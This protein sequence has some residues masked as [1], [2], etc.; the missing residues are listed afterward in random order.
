MRVRRAAGLALLIAGVFSSS[1]VLPSEVRFRE[2]PAFRDDHTKLFESIRLEPVLDWASGEP[3]E[4]KEAVAYE[5]ILKGDNLHYNA[6]TDVYPVWEE[7]DPALYPAPGGG[8]VS[9]K[10]RHRVRIP[11][12]LEES[13]SVRY[14]IERRV[15]AT[16]PSRIAYVNPDGSGMAVIGWLGRSRG[17]LFGNGVLFRDAFAGISADVRYLN[18]RSGFEQDIIIK[19]ELPDPG[20]FG[21]DPARAALVVL[22][23]L[24]DF[25]DYLA[26]SVQVFAG[27]VPVDLSAR[28]A[29]SSLPMAFYRAG[30]GKRFL[31]SFIRGVAYPGTA[32]GDDGRCLQVEVRKTVWEENGKYYLW[33]EIPWTFVRDNPFPIT[34]DYVNRSGV[35]AASETWTAGPTYLVDGTLTLAANVTLTI[36]AG[37]VVKFSDDSGGASGI[38]V[39]GSNS[40]I[41]ALGTAN[42]PIVFTSRNDDTTGEIVPGSS[43]APQSGDYLNAVTLAWNSSTASRIEYGRFA[44]ARQAIEIGTALAGPV[45]HNR[46]E[47]STTGILCRP[48]SAIDLRLRNNLLH[49]LG[50]DGIV[51]EPASSAITVENCTL[52]HCA[53]AGVV[54]EGPAPSTFLRNNLFSLCGIGFSAETLP[55]GNND[56]N[57]YFNNQTNIQG[58]GAES[59]GVLLASSPFAGSEEDPFYLDQGCAL[60]NAGSFSSQSAGLDGFFTTRYAYPRF[61]DQ[62]QVDIGWHYPTFDADNDGMPDAWEEDNDLD[63]YADDAVSD[64]DGD[65]Y[66]NLAEYRGRSDPRNLASIPIRFALS[67][68]DFNGDGT[69]DIGVYRPS[70]SKWYISGVTNVQYGINTDIPVPGDYDGDGTAEIAVFRSSLG[71][72]YVRNQTSVLYGT[73]GDIPLPVDY[74]GDGSAD[75]AVFRPN[76]GRWWIKDQT[77]ISYG[78]IGD[79]PVPGYYNGSAAAVLS[80]FRPSN[81]VWYIRNLTSFAWGA[82]SDF[83]VPG[84]Y[85]GDG[86][87]DPTLFS[88]QTCS[89]IAAPWKTRYLGGGTQTYYFGL[90][91]DIPSPGDYSGGG[92]LTLGVFR[93]SQYYNWLR[94]GMGAVHYGLTGDVPLPGYWLGS[95]SDHDRLPDSWEEF[96]FGDLARQP[97]DDHPDYDQLVN[98]DEYQYG[99][100]PLQADT[101]GDGLSDYAEIHTHL[102]NPTDPDS[103]D[104]SYNDGLEVEYGADPLDPGDVPWFGG[105]LKNAGFEDWNAPG[106]EAYYWSWDQTEDQWFRSGYSYQNQ[107]GGGLYRE[108]STVGSL[109]QLGFSMAGETPYW[110]ALRAK[111]SGQIRL[112]IKYPASTYVSYA[113]WAYLSDAPWTLLQHQAVPPASGTEGGLKIQVCE[114]FGGGL[115]IDNAYLDSSPPFPAPTPVP[116]VPGSVVINEIGWMGSAAAAADEYVELYNTTAQP[117]V[118][119]GW[120]FGAYDGAPSVSL[121]G[122]I[123]A[124][125]YFLL[126]RTDDTT[127]SDLSAD[128]IYSGGLENN[129]ELLELK[130]AAGQTID[131]AGQAEGGWFA[132]D[133]SGELPSMERLDPAVAGTYEWNW[134]SND[135][136]LV[137][138]L[139]ADGNPLNSTPKNLNSAYY[140]GAPSDLDLTAGDGQVGLNWVVSEKGKFDLAGYNIFRK[141]GAWAYQ[142]V[143]AEPVPDATFVD[144]TVNNGT[145]YSYYIKSVDAEGNQSVCSSN[146]ESVT[147]GPPPPLGDDVI[148][149]EV[150][151]DPIGNESLYEWIELFNPTAAGILLDSWWIT[152]GEGRYTFPEGANLSL[153][154][155]EYLIMGA[156]SQ[157]AGGSAEVVYNGQTTSDGDISLSNSG[158][159][160]ILFNAQSEIVDQVS[161]QGN[162]IRE[163]GSSIA[164]KAVLRSSDF[165]ELHNVGDHAVDLSGLRI[166]DGAENDEL[167]AYRTDETVLD[168]SGFALI[169]NNQFFENYEIAVGTILV[170]C[171]DLAIGNGLTPQDDFILFDHDGSTVVSTYSSFSAVESPPENTSV[172]RI[173]PQTGDFEGNWGLCTDPSG[174]TPGRKNSLTP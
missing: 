121:S 174:S 171:G 75:L 8:W 49:D 82:G 116:A 108:A 155:G 35:L 102:T 163:E 17:E 4:E 164:R 60:V 42:G 107:F 125:G 129:G 73:E 5:V 10:N 81:A 26:D 170:T 128:Q 36:E 14:E 106:S 85:D 88:P 25:P 103:D 67:G 123:P 151:F 161:Y 109:S 57:G 112:G 131:A 89:P 63:P 12:V 99:T 32:R 114:C 152:D 50:E 90:Y 52:D 37:A 136:C 118:L 168:P 110:A 153:G 86:T 132:G 96:Y 144:F 172:E 68:G 166:S 20:K 165:I 19:E 98:L 39:A 71:R 65:G 100:S 79:L 31:H 148:I 93:P 54:L 84:D 139:N 13:R 140:P 143:N 29:A 137:N 150:M 169:V 1:S 160:V 83:P 41:V 9:G 124:Y 95:D 22:T 77:S 117:I 61:A 58:A 158:D 142:T 173:N 159:E 147:P 34:I 134:R 64:P 23:E 127:V 66:S 101:D 7:S 135:G 44:Y 62:T 15:L 126:E 51:L 97:Q 105:M 130:D 18:S 119:A 162:W 80:V 45:Q 111:G 3:T 27:A 70:Q 59:H 56:Y 157:A 55:P 122:T 138:G 76:G 38:V 21:L 120:L 154:A 69:V 115:V 94:E 78:L 16:V 43:G 149:S 92:G 91:G 113:D 146:A 87:W 141:E 28:S 30:K 145:Q 2:I 11:P 167:E 133:D 74:N 33:E 156:S 104:D 46:I 72:W 6:G 47:E 24:I 48:A 53:T 40:R